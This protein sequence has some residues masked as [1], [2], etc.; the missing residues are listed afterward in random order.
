MKTLIKEFGGAIFFY[1][2]LVLMVVLI[3]ARFVNM[4]S[5]NVNV[6]NEIIETA[7]L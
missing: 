1:A 2:A 4:Q 5:M 3:N 6:D 7:E